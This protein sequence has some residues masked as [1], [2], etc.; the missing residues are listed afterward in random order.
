MATEAE[1]K[2]W[3]AHIDGVRR[4]ARLLYGLRLT[5]AQAMALCVI[6]GLDM[7]RL[8]LG[9]VDPRPLDRLYDR[10]LTSPHSNPSWVLSDKGRA[11]IDAVRGPGAT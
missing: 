3:Y 1:V 5:E 11:I 2:E 6:G 4:E 10:G 7:G 8:R 9:D